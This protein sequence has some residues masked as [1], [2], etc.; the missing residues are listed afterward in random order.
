LPTLQR[1]IHFRAASV[2]VSTWALLGRAER[3]AWRPAPAART[4]VG[5][6]FQAHDG[7]IYIVAL[8]A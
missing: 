1:S 5:E 3:P 8:L 7:T 4:A 2:G 6:P